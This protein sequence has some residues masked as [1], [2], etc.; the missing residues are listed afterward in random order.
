MALRSVA[1]ITPEVIL[2]ISFVCG[3][4]LDTIFPT[5]NV[6]ISALFV[7]SRV[8]VVVIPLENIC[9]AVKNP[10]VAI[11]PRFK[12]F[13]H[14]SPPLEFAIKKLPPAPT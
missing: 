5:F 13:A 1:V 6:T 3:G 2:V 10:T 9:L 14:T 11:P 4:E 12:L 7:T 8:V